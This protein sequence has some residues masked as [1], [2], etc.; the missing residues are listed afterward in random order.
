MENTNSILEELESVLGGLPEGKRKEIFQEAEEQTRDKKWIPSPGP[1]S[2]AYFCEADT[3]LYGG[4]PGSGKS[5]LLLG[6]AFGAH[7]R[8]LILR[9]QYVDLGAMIDRMLEI[10]GSREGF[11]GQS[12]PSLRVNE[13][14]LVELGAAAK[15]DDIHHWMGNPHDFLGVDEATQFAESQIRFL[16]GWVRSTDPNQRKRTVL[17]T[18]PPLTA[19]GAWIVRMFEPWL[20]PQYPRPAKPGELRWA[21]VDQDGNDRWVNGPSPVMV[22][23]KLVT[24]QSRTYIPATLADNPYLRD[25]GYQS[26]LDAMPEPFRSILL[27]GF[28]T[29]LSDAPAQVIPT[30]WIRN[31]QSRW[32]PQPPDALPMCAIGVDASGGGRDP[33]VIARRYDGWFAPLIVVPAK[34]IP[35]DRAGT[36]C[37]G[38]IV[39]HRRDQAVVTVDLGGGYG[40][41]LYEHL[42]ANGVETVGFRGAEASRQATVEGKLK[43]YNLR[44]EAIWRFR[45]ALNPDQPNGS[46]IALPDD[47]TLTADLTAP[48]LDL[49]F[50]GIK[51]EAKEDVCKRLGRSTDYGDAVVMS[52]YAGRKNLPRIDFPEDGYKP[53]PKR[54]PQVIMR[55]PRGRYG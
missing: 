53:F 38:I 3:L 25:T 19:E 41:S 14:C 15:V 33:M 20:D 31:A 28:Q 49:G 48:C 32:R 55:R 40:S 6:L 26:Q 47:P 2:D 35:T 17:A 9:R 50:N 44:S 4:H 42:K 21:V 30:S 8:S 29:R 10:N 18:N 52:W 7:Q 5:D 46:H 11:N 34:E 16:M 39:S 1:Q 43:F 51:V 37:A 13:K 24:P 12:P 45:E 36:H 22:N 27:G 54:R 23:D